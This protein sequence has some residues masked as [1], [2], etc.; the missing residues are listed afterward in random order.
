V[1]WEAAG[2]HI[3]VYTIN[4]YWPYPDLFA[5]IAAHSGLPLL[6]GEW[7]KMA[8]DANHM[9]VGD[10]LG[11]Q[12]QRVDAAIQRI[13]DMAGQQSGSDYVCVGAHWFQYFDQPPLGR[14]D[15]EKYSVGLVN[16]ENEP[17][18]LL[19][20]TVGAMYRNIYDYLLTG[21]SPLLGAPLGATFP[22]T[23]SASSELAGWE[24]SR[25]ADGARDTVWSSAGHTAASSVEYL[26]IDLG[27][28]Y[29]GITDVCAMPRAG[30]TCFPTDFALYYSTNN[31]TWTLIPGQLY[32]G[33]PSPGSRPQ[34]FR[35]A[36]ITAR[37]LRMRASKL[38]THGS[39]LYYFELAEL[40]AHRGV[41]GRLS[42]DTPTFQWGSVAG[43]ASYTLEYSPEPSFPEGST[44]V[45][46]GIGGTSYT[47]TVALAPGDW[48]WTVQAVD[49]DGDGGHWA[50]LARFVVADPP[51][52]TTPAAYLACDELAGWRNYSYDDAGGDGLVY[53]YLD[54]ATKTEGAASAKV[55]YTI[56]GWNTLTA[57][58]NAATSE[59]AWRWAGDALD[60][61]QLASFEFDLYPGRC[62][63]HQQV[64]TTAAKY[65]WLRLTD[66]SGATLD[67]QL[68]PAGALTYGQW[69]HL[70]VD[71][72]AMQR[73]R[74]TGIEF[75]IKCGAA[76]IPWDQRIQF[77]FDDL[78]PAPS[79]WPGGQWSLGLRAE[80]ATLSDTVVCGTDRRASDG[81]DSYDVAE[82]T[83][84][85]YLSL[86]AEIGGGRYAEDYQLPLDVGRELRDWD[87]VLDTDQSLAGETVTISWPDL[88]ES[89]LSPTPMLSLIDRGTDP[90][91]CVAVVNMREASEYTFT[92]DPTIGVVRRFTLRCAIPHQLSSSEAVLD[93]GWN[94]FCL[95]EEP[96]DPRPAAVLRDPAGDALP[97]SGNLYRYDPIAR[98]YALYLDS[99]PT[100][101]GDVR[102]GEGYWL[103]LTAATAISYQAAAL[104]GVRAIAL[105]TAGWHLIGLP[106]LSDKPLTNLT[107]YNAGAGVTQNYAQA[108]GLG[109]I[110]PALFGYDPAA[111]AYSMIGLDPWHAEATLHPWRGYWLAT[112]TDTLTLNSPAE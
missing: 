33:Y 5:S 92:P 22:R 109:W 59:L 36:P 89:N 88:A 18:T 71:I 111:H 30:G 27:Q 75:Y 86:A 45:I 80:A 99:S 60:M 84:P 14:F 81:V 73:D 43:A 20:S 50:E 39:G 72:S 105:P 38:T 61:S 79:A 1:I 56:F 104:T 96:V 19:V 74:I 107:I 112:L 95:P 54:A 65:L 40:S 76:N 47:P 94:L 108:I 66:A 8:G 3:D 78:T 110:A 106:A 83:S 21:V 34:D 26:T 69:H 90:H 23:A 53:A 97:I 41:A 44:T 48:W 85:P 57:A 32:I 24:A 17:D 42:S 63:D 13:A 6:C 91:G 67:T 25:A 35:F 28:S 77:H 58:S 102:S 51:Q 29:S 4:M 12:P 68:D 10:R 87:L 46:A 11:T 62:V 100:E 82:S 2:R 37:Y 7:N 49:A 15:G 101:F 9:P 70:A 55:T 93:A 16:I 52:H 103:W 31:T 64:T 98:G